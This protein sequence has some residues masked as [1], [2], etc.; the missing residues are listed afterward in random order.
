MKQRVLMQRQDGTLR[1]SI[2]ATCISHEGVDLL[3]LP[4]AALAFALTAASR[5]VLC[6]NPQLQRSAPL[7]TLPERSFE[8]VHSFASESR[9]EQFLRTSTHAASSAQE[10][11]WPACSVARSAPPCADA[12]SDMSFLPGAAAMVAMS[13]VVRQADVLEAALP[14]HAARLARVPELAS[15]LQQVRLRDLCTVAC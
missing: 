5:V 8:S 2:T 10:A 13:D 15:A 3:L 7:E 9:S 12:A 6:S 1:T 4:A 14:L 11:A